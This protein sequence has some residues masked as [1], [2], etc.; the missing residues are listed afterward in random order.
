MNKKIV[1]VVAG[2][3]QNLV[4]PDRFRGYT[5]DGA[6]QFTKKI[7]YA[8]MQMQRGTASPQLRA[9]VE[10]MATEIAGTAEKIPL[11]YTDAGM[12]VLHLP[13]IVHALESKAPVI[14]IDNPDLLQMLLDTDVTPELLADMK[15]PFDEMIVLFEHRGL[16]FE[17]IV[18]KIH[19]DP[20]Y[21]VPD[22]TVLGPGESFYSAIGFA[23]R[24][25]GGKRLVSEMY[26][27]DVSSTNRAF[28][29]AFEGMPET[30]AEIIS[31]GA[32]IFGGLFL[33]L[34]LPRTVEYVERPG[35]RKAIRKAAAD[36]KKHRA[37]AYLFGDVRYAYADRGKEGGGKRAH[38]VRGHF[39]KQQVGSRSAEVREHKTVW[40]EPYYTG[41]GDAEAKTYRLN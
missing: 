38:L 14:A 23:M 31:E 37:P 29:V 18:S 26:D 4:V 34:S 27:F 11:D 30:T 20:S 5:M 32:K 13:M 19:F 12:V 36:F 22:N 1:P 17:A 21:M 8:T 9:Y 3:V 2:I 33:Y 28:K 25:I 40:I 35:V 16:Q 15:L 41:E 6:F 7:Q 39:R 10:E 24:Y